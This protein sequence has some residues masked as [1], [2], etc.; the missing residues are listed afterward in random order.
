MESGKREKRKKMAERIM[1]LPSLRMPVRRY[2]HPTGADTFPAAD[3][4]V[5]GCRRA[6]F[7]LPTRR[8]PQLPTWKP[9]LIIKSRLTTR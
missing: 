9:F 5:S 4:P 1:V 8:F 6:G 2:R 7:R 3:A